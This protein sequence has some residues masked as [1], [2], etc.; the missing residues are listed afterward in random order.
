MRTGVIAIGS[1]VAGRNEAAL[2]DLIGCFVNTLVLRAD[3]SGNPGIR[4][5]LARVRQT[6]LAA[7]AHQDLPFEHLVELLRPP[8][9]QAH[10]PLFQVMLV[11]QDDE[12]AALALPGLAAAYE[13]VETDS[14]K[15]DLTFS[16]GESLDGALDGSI[17]YAADLFDP[18]GIAVLAQRLVRVLE[19]MAAEPDRRIGAID[20]LTSEERQQL[21]VAWND[22][23][24]DVPEMGPAALFEA[25]AARTP[26]AV[27]LVFE[28]TRLSYGDLNARAN[29]L[30]HHLIARGVGPDR[31]VGI[32]LER[33]VEL[34]VAV[35][36]VLKA[37]GAYVPLDP[38][39]P[40]DRL[41]DMLDDAAP[42]LLI[43]QDSL[44]ARWSLPDATLLRLDG[45]PDAFAA[46]PAQNPAAR[47]GRDHLAYVIYTSG[48]TGR[49]KGVQIARAGVVNFLLAMQAQLGLRPDDVLV[50][51]TTLSFDISV[52]EL[53][54]PLVTGARLVLGARAQAADA[55]ALRA[56][57]EDQAATIVQATPT[58][59]RMLLQ[60]GWPLLANPLRVLCG[61][62]AL[63]GDLARQLLV[64]AAELWNLYGPTET[65]IWSALQRIDGGDPARHDTVLGRPIWNT[66]LYVLDGQLQPVPAGVAGELYIAGAGLAR[67]Y[68]GRPGLTAERFVACPFAPGARM[69]RTGDLAKRRADGTLDFLGRADSQVKLRGFRIEPGEI[70]AALASHARVGQAAVVLR[71]DQAD[72]PRLVA[73]VEPK[74]ADETDRAREAQLSFSLF[75]FGADNYTRNDKYA[76]Y[77]DS[78]RFA[79][80]HGFEALWTPERHFHE[81]GSLYPNPS[82]LNAALTG[83]TRHV[84]LRAGSIVLPLHDPL[85]VAEDLAV[86]D[87]LSGGRVGVAIAS[88]WN[89][90]D[91]VFYPERFADRR[92]GLRHAIETLQR[93]WRGEAI[94]RP[95]GTGEAATVRI[96]PEPLQ[97]ALPMWLTAGGTP[98]TFEQAGRSGLNVLT[99]LLGQTM[100]TLEDQIALYRQARSAAGHDPQT[101]RVTLMLHTFVG[102]DIADTLARA[103]GPFM[104]YMRAH[105]DLMRGLVKVLELDEPDES[106]LEQVVEFAFE[107]YS[108]TAS[109]I[110]TPESCLPVIHR[111]HEIG[112][113]EIACLV[114]W[115]DSDQA[116]AA[117]P[118]LARLV[119]L[120]SGYN[121]P[122]VTALREHVASRLP[123]Y[124][125]PS[126]I[127]VLERLPL[128]PNGK[129]DRKALP[130]PDFTP[131]LTRLPR[132]AEEEIL[133][134][135]FAEVLGHETVPVDAN[136]FDL[137][138]HSLLATRLIGR[139]R[140]RFGREV[141]IR[142]LFEAPTVEQLALILAQDGEKIAFG[143]TL[144]LRAH[145][146][147]RPLFC[148][149]DGTGNG[150]GYSTLLPSLDASRPVYAIQA[151]GLW[152]QAALPQTLE[153]MADDYINEI[154]KIQSA[155]PYNLLGYSFGAVAAHAISTRLQSMDEEVGF[156]GLL[157]GYPAEPGPKHST[158]PITVEQQRS[159]I[160]QDILSY[161]FLATSSEG[162]ADSAFIERAIDVII[163]NHVLL[164]KYEPQTFDGNAIL[165]HSQWTGDPEFKPIPALWTEYVNG[166]IEK[167]P[168][169]CDHY[170]LLTH[171]TSEFIGQVVNDKLSVPPSQ[172]HHLTHLV[173]EETG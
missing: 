164:Q 66:R 109:L 79:D 37:G 149:H 95:D 172:F 165:I 167:F 128:T 39:Y 78:A 29:R 116:L 113:D 170:D 48:S 46:L 126:A 77:L 10:A 13:P 22:T 150:L 61:G 146:S 104:N 130:A 85:R 55:A 70:E 50:G 68:L 163:N 31:L 16:L 33:S 76:F 18:A 21:L 49:P 56:L 155:G 118:T 117:L 151:K 34:V 5:V 1:P 8:R 4:E 143:N 123:A 90:R 173:P 119:G 162:T 20:L 53:L 108:R 69:Y 59:W 47:G 15:F 82:L 111:L 74:A 140:D 44:A 43:T 86:V 153:E 101:G 103:R 166:I 30:A 139:I 120:S 87:N 102:D 114:D 3:L 28:E 156:L 93:L 64:H 7:Y 134:G 17:E 63:P 25:Q 135:L 36:A 152:N 23:A 73:Y 145:G 168:V 115:M 147:Q 6:S 92:Q 105:T 131:T 125:V 129:L 72:N 107:R 171:P 9:S 41:E 132:T 84:Q 121:W 91:F 99:H 38:A 161:S 106:Q 40:Q 62:E 158:D 71:H 154:R 127:M 169:S 97:A 24:Q 32:A 27:A 88:G 112:V 98:A 75:Y 67:G 12:M 94:S 141:P 160:R 35:L 124:M 159:K 54:L 100:G 122:R 45:R 110:G 80:A 52:L 83:V 137:G 60:Q 2:D 65:T 142:T 19:T 89:P 157:D 57:L 42:V 148:I 144:T 133:A 51:L 138:G 58:S 136:F 96:Y 81:V 14:T 26:D 11:L